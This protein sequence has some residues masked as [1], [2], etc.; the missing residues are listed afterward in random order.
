MRRQP[1]RCHI[2]RA[3]TSLLL[4]SHFYG[5]V[6]KLKG[7]APRRWAGNKPG[8]RQ[9]HW[10]GTGTPLDVV[11][12][13]CRA[14]PCCP[15]SRCLVKGLMDNA[16][17]EGESAMPSPHL[18]PRAAIHLLYS[19]YPEPA[20]SAAPEIQLP[21]WGAGVGGKDP[22]LPNFIE[23]SQRNPKLPLAHQG[24]HAAPSLFRNNYSWGISKSD[25]LPLLPSS[26][27]SPALPPS[28]KKKKKRQK[29]K[30]ISS[31]GTGQL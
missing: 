17:H 2:T 18:P 4:K 23:A 19:K 1:P 16:H 3:W 28:P 9:G 21:G 13:T 6:G 25:F 20:P 31:S 30:L 14:I 26:V 29:L 24:P 10:L 11:A 27:P 8:Q 15:G 5:G 22:L 12:F 7:T